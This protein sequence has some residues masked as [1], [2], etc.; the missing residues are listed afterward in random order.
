MTD[1]MASDAVSP[2]ST[3]PTHPAYAPGTLPAPFDASN[4]NFDPSIYSAPGSRTSPSLPLTP[5]AGTASGCEE[6]AKAAAEEDKRRRNTAAS[7]RF[8]VKKKQREQALE[9]RE[10][11][12]SEKMSALQKRV[13]QLEQE[14]GF[15]RS[16]VT[17][18][19]GKEDLA[20]KYQKYRRSSEETAASERSPQQT[21]KGVGTKSLGKA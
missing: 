6:A 15:L 3:A 14:N 21:R 1:L 2:M 12:L 5:T 16:L 19:I 4:L 13:G 20:E 8:R 17:E 7:A 9:K 10:R 18:K 11:E